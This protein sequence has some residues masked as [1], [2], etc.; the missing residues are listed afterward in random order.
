MPFD[1]EF[2]VAVCVG[3]LGHVAEVDEPRFLA[4]IH[5]ALVPGGR[6]MFVTTELPS[7]T[8]PAR[9][10]AEIFNGVMRVRNAVWTPPFVM[11]YLTFLWP[12]ARGRLVAAGFTDVE[13]V[14]GAFS[15]P[16]DRA[17]LVTAR[18]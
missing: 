7:W 2:D 16:Y 5:R 18:K 11:Y 14:R 12:N 3:A 9:V 13:V 1:A 10:F 17:L 8:D 4:S 15:K 6:F